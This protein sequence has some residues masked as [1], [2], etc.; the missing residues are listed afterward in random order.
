MPDFQNCESLCHIIDQIDDTIIAHTIFESPR[1]LIALKGLATYERGIVAQPLQFV[2]D[3]CLGRYIKMQ[4][5][6]LGFGSQVNSIHFTAQ[7]AVERQPDLLFC[8]P[9]PVGSSVA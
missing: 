2:E 6:R 1:P 3:A 5:I 8:R 9:A 7:F 4:D